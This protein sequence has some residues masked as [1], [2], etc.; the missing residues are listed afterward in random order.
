MS[1]TSIYDALLLACAVRN[2]LVGQFSPL[3]QQKVEV[4]ATM[5]LQHMIEEQPTV[6]APISGWRGLP[7]HAAGIELMVRDAQF[8]T[9]IRHIE[10]D[11]IAA[12]RQTKRTAQRR[13]R[14]HM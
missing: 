4:A 10:L 7:L 6:A 14:R 1:F 11:L 8:E 12:S 5:G 13:F 9:T 2:V 3:R